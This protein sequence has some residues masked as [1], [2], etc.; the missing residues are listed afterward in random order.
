MSL[1]KAPA[2]VLILL[3]ANPRLSHL[4]M[5]SLPLCHRVWE[6]GKQNYSF[7]EKIHFLFLSWEHKLHSFQLLKLARERYN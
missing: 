1:T 5:K 4:L 6:S 2:I 3:K 7:P